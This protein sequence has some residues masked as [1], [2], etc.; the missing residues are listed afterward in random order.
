MNFPKR[1]DGRVEF[2]FV[3]T[4]EKPSATADDRATLSYLQAI[5]LARGKIAATID[6]VYSHLASVVD[7]VAV[8]K[9]KI[10]EEFA[11]QVRLGNLREANGRYELTARGAA[12]VGGENMSDVEKRRSRFRKGAVYRARPGARS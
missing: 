6:Q 8:S 2:V 10:Q 3:N 9:G 12:V 1:I 5:F 11:D 7:G 4:R